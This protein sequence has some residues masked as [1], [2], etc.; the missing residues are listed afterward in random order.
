MAIGSL[1]KK[2]AENM[3][4]V[5]TDIPTPEPSQNYTYVGALG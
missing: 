1:Q 5:Q 4:I 3:T 2:I